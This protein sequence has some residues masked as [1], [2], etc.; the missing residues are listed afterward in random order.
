MRDTLRLWK[1]LERGEYDVVLSSVVFDELV[2]CYEP[3]RSFLLAGLSKLRYE[4]IAVDDDTV[5]LAGK[6]IDFGILTATSDNDCR[7]IAAALVSG[8]DIT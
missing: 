1:L 2:K 4:R 6:F 8:C 3:K 5:V 7:H